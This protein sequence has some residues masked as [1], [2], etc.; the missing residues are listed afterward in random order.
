M[1]H[2]S[3]KTVAHFYRQHGLQWDEIRQARFVEQ[4]WLDAVLEGLEE[5]GTVLDIGCGSGSPVG[6]YIDSKG[7][8]ITGVDITPALIALCRERL[9]RHRWL[10]GDM[11]TLSLNARFDALIAWDSFFHLTREDQRAMFAIFQQHAKPG[12]KLLFNSGPE[13]GEAVGEF[14]GEPLYHASLSPEEYTQLLNA[15]GFDVLTFRPN[16]AAS[17]GRTVWLAVAR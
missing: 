12:A 1:N 7:F 9:S 3:S 4:P 2:P 17:G 15:H 8:D 5:G 13:N 10:T 11:R 6:M 16:D 14:L